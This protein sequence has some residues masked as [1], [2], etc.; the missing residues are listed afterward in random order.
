M[1]IYE[2]ECQKCKKGFEELIFNT[3]AKVSCPSCKSKRVKRVLSATAIKTGSGFK[4]TAHGGG[5]SG[6]GGGGGHCGHCH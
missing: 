4:S 3:R 1:P 2:F 6:C 5:C